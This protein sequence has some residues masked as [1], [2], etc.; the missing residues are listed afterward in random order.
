MKIS[1]RKQT[2][3]KGWRKKYD[4]QRKA[5][6]AA[7]AATEPASDL[8]P[9]AQV[10]TVSWFVL[11]QSTMIYIFFSVSVKL[12]ILLLGYRKSFVSFTCVSALTS[13]P[14][15][16]LDNLVSALATHMKGIN[17]KEGV[18]SLLAPM[19]LIYQ[20]QHQVNQESA[21][22]NMYWEWNGS[23]SRFVAHWT[24]C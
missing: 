4:E 7:A 13:A 3:R 16:C 21:V 14:V 10:Q 8:P 1:K 23:L 6:A 17:S 12:V 15:I 24:Q 9:Q 20:W 19:S 22:P 2:K 11:T 5:R 18:I